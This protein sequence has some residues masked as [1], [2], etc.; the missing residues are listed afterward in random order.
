MAAPV[1]R[2]RPIAAVAISFGKL[3][4]T[5]PVMLQLS[6]ARVVRSDERRLWP[7]SK[8]GRRSMRAIGSAGALV[9]G[10]STAFA[11]VHTENASCLLIPSRVNKF[12]L[13]PAV[14]ACRLNRVSIVGRVAH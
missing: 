3:L 5:F 13:T 14:L 6:R 12:R 8:H 1:A 4:P 9:K 7:R 2:C 11:T 10:A